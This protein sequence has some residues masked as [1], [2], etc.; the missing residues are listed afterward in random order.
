MLRIWRYILAE[1]LGPT[2]MGVLVYTVLFL[3]NLIFQLAELAIRKSIGFWLLGQF[4]ALAMPRLLSLVIPM[5]VL[6]GILIAMG[7]LSADSEITA[8]RACGVSYLQILP[9]VLTLGLLGTVVSLGLTV[10]V[11]PEATYAQHRLNAQILLSGDLNRNIQ[12]RVFFQEI[13]GLLIYADR[14]D[15]SGGLQDVLLVQENRD[16]LQQL[17]L[18][19]WVRIE[20]DP[21]AGSLRIRM[22][23]GEMHTVSPEDPDLYE[24]TYFVDQVVTRPPDE[25]LLQ[26]AATLRGDLPR[27]LR[28]MRT[29]D[30]GRRLGLAAADAEGIPDWNRTQAGIEL[31]RRLAVPVAAAIFSLLGASLGVVTRRGG[32]STGFA[33]SLGVILAYWLTMSAAENLARSGAMEVWKAVWLSNGIFS[34]LGVILMVWL[35]FDR[36]LPAFLRRLRLP[37]RRSRATR[38]GGLQPQG[39]ARREPA[40]RR[41]GLRVGTPWLPE[42][43]DRYVSAAF[44]RI[45]LLVLVSFCLFLILADL[46][47]LLDDLTSGPGVP[48]RTLLA[49]FG[50]S[51]PGLLVTGLPLAA[52]LATIL[53]FATLERYNEVTAMKASGISA[54]RLSLPVLVIGLLLSLGQFMLEESLVPQSNKEAAAL[55]AQI[56]DQQPASTFGLRRWLFGE[57]GRVYNLT[58]YSRSRDEFQGVSMFRLAPEL[59]LVERL[60]AAGARYQD[61]WWIFR[62][63]WIRTFGAEGERYETFDEM[64]L[65]LPE[66]PEQFRRESKVPAQM[67]YRELERHITALQRAGYDVQELEVALFEKPAMAAVPLVLVLIGLSY[68][69]RA[70][71]RGRGSLAG[72]GLA[73]ML[74]IAYYVAQATC[75]ELGAV[76]IIPP[77]IAAWA[78]CLL[79]SGVGAWRMLSLP[80]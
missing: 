65:R 76:G 43:L 62:D 44:L 17:T 32:R 33:V 52:L 29:L 22:H 73:I 25:S 34:V 58:A 46:R 60:Q 75:R 66:T 28:E 50:F 9:P 55:R 4:L 57:G 16:G 30:L 11:V 31:H 79:F 26:F 14:R 15:P 36:R 8:L 64:R 74:A 12:P 72:V 3:L 45:F 61:G 1:C 41:G 24:R 23:E 77:L 39:A 37:R 70:G 48:A 53:A 35:L 13:P 42:R 63:G 47:T 49:Y 38:R 2:L 71:A 7:R 10:F 5:S 6:L 18:A 68:A 40:G 21:A 69:F 54:Y 27:N 51:T 67:T 80:T 59:T 56:R 78:P 19:R 20:Q